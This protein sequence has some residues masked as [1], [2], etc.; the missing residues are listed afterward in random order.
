[1]VGFIVCAMFAVSIVS[2]SA[3]P[4]PVTTQVTIG[5]TTIVNGEIM[6]I[7]SGYTPIG[8]TP[9]IMNGRLYLPLSDVAEILGIDFR[10]P[11]FLDSPVIL[12]EVPSEIRE[13]GINISMISTSSHTMSK[14]V[15][16]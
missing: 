14:Q 1:M 15:K 5:M 8:R 6:G 2:V 12:G 10:Y 13:T 3:N 7:H 4:Q 9:F 11:L 16:I